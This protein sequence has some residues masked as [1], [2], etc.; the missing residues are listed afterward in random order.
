MRHRS[1]RTLLV[2][3]PCASFRKSGNGVLGPTSLP[4]R[5]GLASDRVRAT[6]GRCSLVSSK[7]RGCSPPARPVAKARGSRS[8][9]RWVPLVV[10]ESIAVHGVCLTVQ[11]V[12]ADGFDCDATVETLA[13]TTLGSL[14][15]GWP[16]SP[17]AIPR[18]SG[19]VGRH[20]VSGH[21]D[22]KLRLRTRRALSEA[23]ELVFEV[24]RSVTREVHRAEGLGCHQWR[25]PHGQRRGRLGVRR[26]HHSP[27]ARGHHA[28]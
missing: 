26:G 21:V 27:Y 15:A 24:R 25:E 5:R 28:G 22:G 11:T 9:P 10:G 4:P 17:R 13:C 1:I 3:N 7:P 20:I 16:R 23:I 18:P 12:T 8:R 19:T 6:P 14:P 2:C